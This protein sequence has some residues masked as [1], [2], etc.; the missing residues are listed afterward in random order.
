MNKTLF[1]I[2]VATGFTLSAQAQASVYADFPITVKGYVGSKTYSESFAGQMARHTLHN[3]VKKLVSKGASIEQTSAYFTGKNKGR[4]IIDPVAKD[5]FPVLQSAVDDLSGGKNLAG[6]A[7]KGLITGMP[8][9][10]TGA[11]L[12]QLMLSKASETENGYDPLTGYD[13]TQLISKFTMGAVFYNQAV[14]NY[15]DEKLAADTKPNN[16]AYKDGAAYTGKEHVWDEAFGYFGAPA[17][18]LELTPKEVYN[19]AKQKPEGFA[20]ADYNGDGKVS[21]VNEMA[22]AHAYYAAAFDKG[23]KTQYLHTIVQAFVDGRNL[24]TS[25]NGEALTDAQRSELMAYAKVIKTQW[26]RLIAEAVFKY[27]GSVY[28][29][30]EKL[31]VIIEAN[32]DAVKAYR[33]YV[34]HWGEL[35]GFALALEAGGENLG[36]TGVKLNR[37]LGYSPVLLGNT[38]VVALVDGEFVQS[39]S[40]SLSEYRVHMI[41]VQK[42][43]IDAFGVKARSKDVTA[44]LAEL[45]NAL[46]DALA[47][48]ND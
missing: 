29:D 15:L 23:G 26:Q 30:I 5:G 12:L 20:K 33:S 17:H 10:L 35:K 45:V 44:N 40:I 43:M 7:Y 4:V 47:A 2:L 39:S 24:I 22:Y 11:E 31:E 14:D 27:A 28:G 46:G 36:E 48:E 21:L 19:I 1:S 13:Y 18:T 6:K 42:L 25:A 16:K 3:S 9:S 37:L 8:G 41:K 32:G 34:K 38:Q